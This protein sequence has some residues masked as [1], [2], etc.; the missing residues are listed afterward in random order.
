MSFSMTYEERLQYKVGRVAT[1]KGNMRLE[2]CIQLKEYYILNLP[3]RYGLLEVQIPS[4]LH[5]VQILKDV[6]H[7]TLT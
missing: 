3:Y 2:T 7:I 5:E 4:C 6:I 1:Q